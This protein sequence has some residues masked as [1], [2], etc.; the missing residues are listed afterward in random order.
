MQINPDEIVDW[1]TVNGVHIPIK[2][3]QSKKD[4]IKEFT[5]NKNQQTEAQDNGET[6]KSNNQKVVKINLDTEVQKQLTAAKTSKERQQIAFRYILDNLRGQYQTSDG[7]TVSIGR[8]GANKMT[9]ND[10]IEKL[11]VTP[12][13]AE[14][15]KAGEYDHSAPG[16]EKKN[17]KFEEFAY[18]KV[19]VK[20]GKEIYQGMLNVGIRKDGS[21][22]L[23]DLRP[24][25][26]DGEEE[27]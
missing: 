14:M 6:A 19:R 15:I 24:F 1:I 13:L 20:V 9:H 7:R 22:T 11:R 25:Y 27:E 4:A 12:A 16:E 18:Y 3:G 26:K 21:S 2:K 17:K 23:Y 8:V 5:S 10:K